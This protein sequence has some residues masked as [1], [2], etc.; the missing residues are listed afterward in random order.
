MKKLILFVVAVAA[1]LTLTSGTAAADNTAAGTATSG[2]GAADNTAA[3]TTAAAT[4]A[5]ADNA[6]TNTATADNAAPSSPKAKPGAIV[7]AGNARFTV[8]TDRLIRMEWAEDGKF[9]DRASLAII[10]RDLPVPAFKA[11]KQGGGVTISTGKLTLEYK[12]GRFAPG[13]LSVTFKLNGKPVVWHPGDE[14]SG[15]LKGTTRTLDGCNGWDRL[16]H[17]EKELENG[18]LSR[19]GWAIVDESSRHLL[20]KD[21][22]SW[23][24]WVA[25]RPEGDR[26]DW[27]IFAYGHDYLAA[28]Q[29]FTKVAGNIPLPPRFV[30]GYWWS[31][32]WIYTDEELL[33]LADD[34]RQRDIPADVFIIDMDWHETWKPMN[35]R[36]GHDEFGQRRG[37]T[38]YTWNRDLIPD[39]EGL[40]AELHRKG[41]KTALN[42]HPASGIRPYEDC[43]SR[44]VADYL[45]RTDDYDGPEGYIYPEQGWTYK[46]SDTPVGREGWRA[47]VP[48]RLDQ[49]EWADA[50]FN[51]VIHPLEKQG[52]DFWWLDWQQWRESKYVKGLSNTFWCNYCFWNDQVRRKTAQSTWP[53]RPLI[54]HRWGGL[55]SHRYQ[56]GFSG[57]TYTEW[58]V[59]QFLP[60]FTSTASNVGYG[61]WGHDIG[62]HMQHRDKQGPRDPELY[63]R[64]MQFGV[65]TPI[66]KT[67]A[68]QNANLDCRIWIFPDHY[69]YLKAAIK[70]RYALS[71]YIYD[72]AHQATETGVSMCRP[73]YYYY[74]ELAE[75]YERNEE[76]FF[77]DNIL[78]TAITAPCGADGTASREVWLPKGEW[79]DMSH[80]RLLKGG[81]VYKL[82]Y[83]LEQNP[84]FVKAGAV[85]PMAP[86]G[87]TN[88]QEQSNALRLMIVPGK[89]P[90]KIEHYE[91]DGVSQAYERV[92][93]TT[94]IEK[95]TAGGKTVVKI[96]PRKGSYAGAPSSRLIS[97]ELEGVNKAPAQVRCN[98]TALPA[99]AVCTGGGR[100][101][102]TLPEAPADEALRVEI[103]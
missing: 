65:F 6:A 24:E 88:L 92:F 98:G 19:D 1:A 53:S 8:L 71:P 80:E 35:E 44:F 94:T 81:K 36:L 23:G 85:I 51:S 57:D 38:G 16:S 31:R 34:M 15:N 3:A 54:Y 49:Q 75:A 7:I 90:C 83:T 66:F 61:Y 42:L 84:W 72:A 30:F 63:T 20:Q 52:V 21:S 89:A 18:I 78:A 76:Y 17:N 50:Y 40:L 37:W 43:Y 60:Y 101:T 59:L 25:E 96:G 69:E 97:I 4:T 82:N 47:P 103:K 46:G 87:I 67:H 102:I 86:E 62:G 100:T 48:F 91:D 13:N 33:Q 28:L 77:G 45:S 22:S 39:P 68:T 10:N 41:F 55:G 74:P 73:L 56:L 99:S 70:L 58:S 29:D 64:W 95:S 11:T 5:T 79:Y 26:I 9:E 27:Y 12:G 93:A 2:T 14:P 32:Y